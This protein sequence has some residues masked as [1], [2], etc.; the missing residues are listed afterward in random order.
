MNQE[1]K[2][3]LGFP[4]MALVGAQTEGNEVSFITGPTNFANGLMTRIVNLVLQGDVIKAKVKQF[5]YEQ[6]ATS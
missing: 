1:V 6:S 3:F 4:S 2:I 5:K